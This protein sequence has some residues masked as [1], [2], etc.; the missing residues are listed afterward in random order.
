MPFHFIFQLFTEVQ[1]CQNGILTYNYVQFLHSVCRPGNREKLRYSQAEL[2]PAIK[3]A[4]AYFASISG[5][6][7]G[8][9]ELYVPLKS[10][11]LF[12]A[13][14]HCFCSSPNDFPISIDRNKT[15]GRAMSDVL[16]IHWGMVGNSLEKHWT[17]G[18][19]WVKSSFSQWI[20]NVLS[21]ISQSLAKH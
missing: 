13:V 18:I 4:V 8:M 20:L 12:H 21:I 19:R 2:G 5:V 17:L 3:S 7:N 6:A 9:Q 16:I 11:Y 10:Y 1:T 15:N 14:S